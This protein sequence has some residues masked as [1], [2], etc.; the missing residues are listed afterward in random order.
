[1]SDSH[2]ALKD[3]NL[4]IIESKLVL[5]WQTFSDNCPTE[6]GLHLCW[7]QE[8]EESKIADQLAKI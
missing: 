2:P 8:I 7:Y 6:T 4:Q 3:L 5:E 1:V